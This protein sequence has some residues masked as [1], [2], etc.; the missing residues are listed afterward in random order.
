MC[1]LRCLAYAAERPLLCMD[2]P[3]QGCIY[4]LLVREILRDIRREERTRFVPARQ[5]AAYLPRTAL[6]NCL[7]LY[8]RRKSSPRSRFSVFFFFI[9]FSLGPRRHASAN[10]SDVPITVGM[11]NDQNAARTRYSD[12]NKT[13]FPL[14]NDPDRDTLSPKDRQTRSPLRGMRPRA[15][16]DFVGP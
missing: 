8:S 2:Q 1:A 14:R 10:N 4:G 3:A 7:R 15:S 12:G 9:M 6:F 13:L 16:C 5:R 11:G